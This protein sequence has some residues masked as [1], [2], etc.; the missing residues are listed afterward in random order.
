MQELLNSANPDNGE[1]IQTNV[2]DITPVIQ[3]TTTTVNEEDYKNLQAF[4]TQNRQALIESTKKLVE[5]DGSEIHNITDPKLR[6]SVS[7]AIFNMG[8]AEA[9]AVFGK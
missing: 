2:E 3:P 1:V 4:A 8:Y 5:K 9:E 6:D 7:R